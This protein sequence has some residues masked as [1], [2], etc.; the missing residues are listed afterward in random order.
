MGEAGKLLTKI[1]EALGFRRDTVYITNIVKCRPPGNRAPLPG[2]IQACSRYLDR[3]L[4][5]LQPKVVCALGRF[6]AQ[7][8]IGTTVPISRLRGKVYDARGLKIVPT[9][10]PAYLLR[11]PEG[12]K[13]T[14]ADVQLARAVYEGK[15]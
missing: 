7:T 5:V 9:Y 10:H 15:V 11:N 6:S 13:D 8:L 4:E 14:W 3:Q 1:I 12:K 2:E